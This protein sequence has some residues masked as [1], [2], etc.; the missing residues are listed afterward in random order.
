MLS[1]SVKE[2][3]R[4]LHLVDINAISVETLWHKAQPKHSIYVHSA[5]F[6][7]AL[8]ASTLVVVAF[9]FQTCLFIFS[10]SSDCRCG[11]LDLNAARMHVDARCKGSHGAWNGI[12]LK[13]LDT[14]TV[15]RV[16]PRRWS[17]VAS[18]SAMKKLSQDWIKIH[19]LCCAHLESS[20]HLLIY[21]VVDF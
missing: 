16:A 18:H 20:L 21:Y 1:S 15:Q 14:V 17:D 10:A 3:W 9:Y 19:L 12:I 2:R 11:L 7:S 8:F 13:C 4:F 6:A 5:L